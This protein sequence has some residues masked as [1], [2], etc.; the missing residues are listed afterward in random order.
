MGSVRKHINGTMNNMTSELFNWSAPGTANTISA[1][2]VHL[3]YSEDHFIQEIIQGKPTVWAS[4]GW[5]TKSGIP[6]PPDI[7]EK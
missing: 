5:N 2:F 1:T 7:S 6:K 3:M 4:G